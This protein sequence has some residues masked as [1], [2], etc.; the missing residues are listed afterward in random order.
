MN[1]IKEIEDKPI[2]IEKEITEKSPNWTPDYIVKVAT[3][4][5]DDEVWLK[6]GI[7]F[8]SATV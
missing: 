3:E 5:K 8:L 2:Y 7:D 4:N 6:G 1:E